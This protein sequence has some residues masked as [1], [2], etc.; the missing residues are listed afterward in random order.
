MASAFAE[1]REKVRAQLASSVCEL[2]V[3]PHTRSMPSYVSFELSDGIAEFV[4]AKLVHPAI[5]KCSEEFEAMVVPVRLG[6]DRA[7]HSERQACL[8]VL[9]EVQRARA[10]LRGSVRLFAAHTPC[11]SCLACICQLRCVLGPH[12]DIAV[13]FDLWKDTCRA[14]AALA[15]DP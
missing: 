11:C 13:D 14:A 2:P 3:E 8:H 4:G 9:A 7:G 12:V 15:P 10:P 5:S 6:N 1:G